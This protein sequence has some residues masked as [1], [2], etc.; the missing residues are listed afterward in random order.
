MV[1]VCAVSCPCSLRVTRLF[2]LNQRL[3]LTSSYL[4]R[5]GGPLELPVSAPGLPCA[6]FQ[7][8]GNI[9]LRQS[10]MDITLTGTL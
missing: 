4:T 6:P 3:P 7:I 5:T 2:P 10:L 8:L 9:D 1:R